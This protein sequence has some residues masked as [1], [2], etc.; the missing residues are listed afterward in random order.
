MSIYEIERKY[1]VQTVPD[2]V[3]QSAR[4]PMKQG[5]LVVD[6]QRL[7]SVRIRREGD[8]H[9][10]TIK[11][12]RGRKRVE[13]ER[14]LSVGEFEALWPAVLGG[15]TKWRHRISEGPHPI[16]VDIFEG[17]LGGLTLAEVEFASES[18]AD[19]FTP[20]EWFGEE[21]TDDPRYL[22]Q[23]LALQGLPMK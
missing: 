17:P 15:L 8:A 18:E 2:A 6:E 14:S 1:L 10:L 23:T 5:Y 11:Q 9:R 4:L 3:S 19:A 13:I 21:V 7:L 12:G 16:D 20:P 22:N